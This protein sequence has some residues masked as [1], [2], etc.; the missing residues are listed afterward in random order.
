MAASQNNGWVRLEVADTG[1]GIP[2]EQLPHVFERFYRADESRV[3]RGPG[4]LDRPPDRRVPRGEPLRRERGGE[5]S[6]F[7]LQLPKDGPADPDA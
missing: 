1:N 5:G 4:A 2:E 3:T 7:A 6:T